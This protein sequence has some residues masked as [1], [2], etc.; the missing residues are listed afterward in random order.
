MIGIY[1]IDFHVY[2]LLVGVFNEIS[3]EARRSLLIKY[4]ITIQ[5]SPDQVNP[6]T[7]IGM[8]RHEPIIVSR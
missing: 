5:R 6:A 4:S 2:G 8:R 3:G 1:E 7:R